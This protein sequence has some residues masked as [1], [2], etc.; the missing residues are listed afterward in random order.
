MGTEIF[1]NTVLT[2]CRTIAALS[3]ELPDKSHPWDLGHSVQ[4]EVGYWDLVCAPTF[5][6]NSLKKKEMIREVDIS[7]TNP[8]CPP[9]YYTNFLPIAPGGCSPPATGT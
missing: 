8:F 7:T 1:V 2:R 9:F 3:S 5:L 6:V 4:T